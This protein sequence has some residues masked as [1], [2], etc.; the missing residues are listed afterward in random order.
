MSSLSLFVFLACQQSF[1]SPHSV[2]VRSHFKVAFSRLS[3]HEPNSLFFTIFFSS[4]VLKITPV[5]PR[6]LGLRAF[7][8]NSRLQSETFTYCRAIRRARCNPPLVIKRSSLRTA[9]HPRQV[10]SA[11]AESRRVLHWSFFFSFFLLC[12][13]YAPGMWINKCM[14]NSPHWLYP[15]LQISRGN[16]RANGTFI[17]V[18]TS[19]RLD[20]L[21][22]TRLRVS[23][24][25]TVWPWRVCCSGSPGGPLASCSGGHPLSL[26]WKPCVA[27]V[28]LKTLFLPKLFFYALSGGK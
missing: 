25:L 18:H 27:A 11:G 22:H 19:S 9:A 21:R 12:L 2:V 20:N 23:F 28:H 8:G 5:T 1:F 4:A 17:P 7:P 16:T 10:F 14:V 3:F 15:T 6:V 24:F 13:S 26:S